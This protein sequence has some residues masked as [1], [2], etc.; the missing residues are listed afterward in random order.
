MLFVN[1]TPLPATLVPNAEASDEISALLVAA[2]TYRFVAG[3]IGVD[4]LALTRDQRPLELGDDPEVPADDMFVRTGVSVIAA[5]HIHAPGG[6]ARR[7]ECALR[8]GSVSRTIVAFGPRVWQ[9]GALGLTASE[10][11]KFDRI[12]MSWAHTYGGKV[13]RPPCIVTHQGRDVIVPEHE[14]AFP[15]NPEGKG[16]YLDEK[17]AENKP[18]PLIEDAGGLVSRYDDRPE[19]LCFAPYPTRGG[20]RML[21]TVDAE[22]RVDAN[23]AGRTTTRAAPR[24][25]FTEIPVGTVISVSGLRSSGE[26]LAFEV[27]QPPVSLLVEVDV[28]TQRLELALDA[29]EI[30]GDRGD[31]RLVYRTIFRYPLIEGHNRTARLEATALFASQATR[32]R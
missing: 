1:E 8:V 16:F 25:V 10:A 30:D 9:K 32:L 13:K 20:L 21:T 19:P 26:T 31:V 2:I 5:G 6:E 24:M 23:R 29:I 4:A 15:L 11:L 27:P 17:E 12:P 3:E 22:G 18:L 28:V 14:V 7:A